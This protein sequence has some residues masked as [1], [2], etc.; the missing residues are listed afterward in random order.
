MDTASSFWDYFWQYFP[1]VFFSSLG[2]LQIAA[3]RA[4]LK[5]LTFFKRP[6]PCYLFGAVAI[7]GAFIWFYAT[8]DRNTEPLI[9][10]DDGV[11]LFFGETQSFATFMAGAFCA[12]VATILVSSVVNARIISSTNKGAPHGLDALKE[13]TFFQAITRDL[14][15]GVRHFSNLIRG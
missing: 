5:G 14:A 11:K 6:L 12:L 10:I 13:M 3:A 2:V 4:D 1:L 7:V 8:G 15:K 9:R